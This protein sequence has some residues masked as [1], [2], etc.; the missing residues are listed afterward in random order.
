MNE[1]RP[2]F[3]LLSLSGGSLLS[4]PQQAEQILLKPMLFFCQLDT[5][6]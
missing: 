6:M 5:P 3:F 2:S 1:D 4:R